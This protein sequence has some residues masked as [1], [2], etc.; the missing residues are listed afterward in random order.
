MRQDAGPA[1]D[2]QACDLDHIV[3]DLHEEHTSHQSMQL[4]HLGLTLYNC[5]FNDTQLTGLACQ[6]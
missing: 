2:M 3:T 4:S 1:A 5:N 6:T